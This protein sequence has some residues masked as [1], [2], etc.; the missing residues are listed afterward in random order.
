[1]GLIFMWRRA[2]E[3]SFKYGNRKMQLD[4]QKQGQTDPIVI[5]HFLRVKMIALTSFAIVMIGG[6]VFQAVDHHPTIHEAV[7]LFLMLG[8]L[9][10]IMGGY[11]I[12][13]A[14][15]ARQT[16][17]KYPGNKRFLTRSAVMAAAVILVGFAF[18]TACYFIGSE[19]G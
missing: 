7:G 10:L 8:V 17:D 3:T 4:T 1:M 16:I 14:R 19:S 11:L 18:F 15:T 12:H 13:I 9:M 2:Y 6:R 5:G